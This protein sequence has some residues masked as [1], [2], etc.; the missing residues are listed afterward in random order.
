MDTDDLSKETYNAI[1]AEAERFHP[2]LTLQFGLL[3]Y[4]C[5]NEDEFLEKSIRLIT[6]LRNLTPETLDD[7][8]FDST[9]DVKSFQK[10]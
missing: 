6:K 7:V 5:S 8:F 9:P 3:S 1:I 10:H 4:E 2:D